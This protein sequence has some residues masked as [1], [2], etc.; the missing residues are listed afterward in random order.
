MIIKIHVGDRLDITLPQRVLDNLG[1]KVEDSVTL[2]VAFDGVSLILT[3][4][5]VESKTL[6]GP[7]VRFSRG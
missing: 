7:K 4:T 1:W 6:K 3:P 2:D 5:R